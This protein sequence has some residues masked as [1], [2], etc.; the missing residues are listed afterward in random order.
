MAPKKR[1]AVAAATETAAAPAAGSNRQRRNRPQSKNGAKQ[2][3]DENLD[4]IASV[5]GIDAQQIRPLLEE[6]IRTVVQPQLAQATEDAS[7]AA[8]KAAE[9]MAK[10]RGVEHQLNVQMAPGDDEEGSEQPPE[11]RG[12]AAQQDHHQQQQQQQGVQQQGPNSGAVAGGSAMR[13][14]CRSAG[15]S[16]TAMQQ[17]LHGAN[18]AQLSQASN[19]IPPHFPDGVLE[20]KATI[21]RDIIPRIAT[22]FIAL[23]DKVEVTEET[24]VDFND[25]MTYLAQAISF[26]HNAITGLCIARGNDRASA[27]IADDYY[28]LAQVEGAKDRDYDK[29]N[30]LEPP[31]YESHR[32]QAI[33][34]NKME[35]NGARGGNGG[36]GGGYNGGGRGRGGGRFTG[37]G[38]GGRGWPG[39]RPYEGADR[40]DDRKGSY[41]RNGKDARY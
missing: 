2:T 12:A 1:K 30:P 7:A 27:R 28:A 20:K 34:T 9:A 18:M 3:A 11:Q 13:L 26:G 41:G 35:D 19:M 14:A 39:K 31:V 6:F 5:T 15:L 40:E 36:R 37:G 23:R 38:E 32:K 10:A 25:A 21:L 16:E 33:K 8:T 29:W 4:R 24:Q 17:L 22:A